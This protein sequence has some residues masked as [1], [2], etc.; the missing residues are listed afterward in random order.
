MLDIMLQSFGIEAK[1]LQEAKKVMETI[2]AIPKLLGDQMELTEKILAR[3]EALETKVTELKE[4]IT[5]IRTAEPIS[6]AE[7]PEEPTI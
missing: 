2:N 7:D 3:I 5:P 4:A 6:N 1:D